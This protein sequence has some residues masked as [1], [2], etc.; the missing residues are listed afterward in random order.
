MV[1]DQNDIIYLKAKELRQ[2]IRTIA[3]AITDDSNLKDKLL[4]LSTNIP[5]HIGLSL[6]IGSIDEVTDHLFDARRKMTELCVVIDLITNENI[7]FNGQKVNS[8]IDEIRELIPAQFDKAH[9]EHEL[10][11]EEMVKE[12][13]AMEID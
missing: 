7:K 9:K 10:W 2:M 6:N 8:L 3:A 11:M 13:N 4:E 5:L 1:H 12:V